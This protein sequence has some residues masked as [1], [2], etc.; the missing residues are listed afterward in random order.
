M[1]RLLRRWA[2]AFV[3]LLLVLLPLA[4]MAQQQGLEIDIVGGNAAAL[5]IAVVPMPYQGSGAAPATDVAAV[6]S[7]DLARS[8]QFRTLPDRDMVERPTSSSQVNYPTWR[9]LKQDFLVV[10]RV[11]DAGDGN[12]RLEYELFDVAKQQRL[13]GFALSAR[14]DAMR[15]VA[16][17]VSDAIYEKILGVR[18]AFW[19]RIAYVTASGLGKSSRYALV[20]AD[21]DGFN[22]R[23]VFRDSQPILSPAWSPDGHHLAF[24]SFHSGNSA[25]YVIDATRDTS[26]PAPV[27]S[28]R[29][30]NGA[31]AFSPDGRRLALTLSKSGNPEIYVMDLGSKALRQV[32]DQF[33]IDTE[34]VWSPDGGS[35]Y[36]T[37]D[38]GGKPQI[39]QV[40][41]NG[42]SATRLTFQGS[43]NASATVSYDGKK[44]AVA[45]G[46]GNNFRI[47]MLD[48]SL[49]SARWST[50]SPGSLDES[51]SF[52]PN[53]S[54]I[55]YAAR[56]GSRG[57]L[58]AVS[59]DGRVRQRLVLADGDVREPA[60]GPYRQQR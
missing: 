17:Q 28:F 36:F 25:I 33:G 22:P 37:S 10:G 8:G 20:V 19:T 60:W 53:A 51:P 16:H 43:Y 31:P 59:A 57:V 18:G 11:L 48:R 1:N 34:A 30:I 14:G 2:P 32:T 50:L 24:V 6:I 12:Y 56:E 42:G 39:Y 7:A 38:R 41:A 55:L 58:Y 15:D 35:L 26:L 29:G 45:Q 3:S 52:A 46:N 54:M 21:S 40:S 4:A 44:V 13:L 23:T 5:P 9:L 47:A 49:G 27:A